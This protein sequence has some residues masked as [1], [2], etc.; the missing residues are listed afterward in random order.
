MATIAVI[1][2]GVAGLTAAAYLQENG[3]SV[4]VFEQ[5]PELGGVTATL[6]Q[7]GFSWDLG[8]MLLEG[9]GRGEPAG[10]ILEE[11][12]IQE[13]LQLQREERGLV[14]PDF[15]I[16]PQREYR[17]PYWRRDYLKRVFP[18]D[19]GGLDRYYRF[20]DRMMDLMALHWRSEQ[21]GG[22]RSFLLRA[23]TWRAFQKVREM[24]EWSAAQLMDHFF[25]GPELKALYTSIL[26]DFVVRPSQFSALAVPAINVETP[27][28]KRMPLQVSKAGPRP[29][30]HYV[31][32]GCEKLVALLADKIRSCGG[33]IYTN[34][35]VNRIAVQDGRVKGIIHNDHEFKRADTVVASGGVREVMFD[36]VGKEH[37]PAEF[38]SRVNDVPLMESVHM[39]H[40]GVEYDIGR[41]QPGGLCYYYQTY[42]IEDAVNRCQQGIYHEG[43]DGFLVYVPSLHSPEMAPEGLHAVT[44]YTIAPN[45]LDK[46]DWASRGEELS[47]TL[48]REVEKYLPGLR[49]RVKTT[50]IMTP[51]EFKKRTHLKHHA[52]GGRAPVMGKSGGPHR[53]PIDGLWFIGSQ[54][55]KIGGGVSGTMAASRRVVQMILKKR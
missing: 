45:H 17:G 19:S 5:Y 42:D 8:P 50:V 2:S 53:T 55:E 49:K 29:S 38:I 41:Y 12:G 34:T 3:H 31:R 10:L 21:T 9:F 24:S 6:K 4:T 27:F 35:P 13:K 39:I 36:L 48:L 16:W 23:R 11:L 7:D 47:D 43:R 52:F 14:F 46:G 32:G 26:A 22:L 54:S 40:L 30:Y 18:S 33:A 51:D 15:S 44:V 1:G 37:L 20:Y 25:Q 28:D